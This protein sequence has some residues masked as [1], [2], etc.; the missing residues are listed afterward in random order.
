[1]LVRIVKLSFKEKNIPAFLENFELI[2]HKIRSA[3]GNR[4]VELYQDKTDKTLFFTYS[5]WATE[6]DL[7]NYRLSAFFEEVWAFTK[8]LF[9]K[10]PEAWSVNVLET[11]K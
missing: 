2:K 10:K 6:Q 11:L 3:P 4:L 1:M 7:Q 5:H 8:K 9:D